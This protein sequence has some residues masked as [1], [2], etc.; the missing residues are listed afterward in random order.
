MGIPRNGFAFFVVVCAAFVGVGLAGTSSQAKAQQPQPNGIRI[1]KVDDA[2]EGEWL[3]VPGYH[4]LGSPTF[5]RDGEWIAFDA[6]KS[7]TEQVTCE[8]WIVRRNG[9]DA[10]KVTVGATPR[11]HPNGRTLIFMRE[12]RNE[13]ESK[14]LGIFTIDRD[15]G[16]ETFLCPGRWPDWSPDGTQI[17]FSHGAENTRNG[18]SAE[19]S[20][21]YVALANGTSPKALA[22][23]DCPSWSSD[24]SKIA[25]CFTDP[26]LPAPLIR[27]I[28]LADNGQRF[29]GYGW[30]RANWDKDG[31]A[32]AFNG[33]TEQQKSGMVS[34]KLG[35]AMKPTALATGI[36][37]ASSPCYSADG[38]YIVFT[39]PH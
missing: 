9:K 5:S 19:L 1:Q 4:Y 12:Q 30:F 34:V 25:C 6:Y 33:V 8:V 21:V 20:R 29:A 27:I 32:V 31:K 35:A 16:A 3:T 7:N 18:G 37:N 10:K 11:W 26:A 22:N 15:G 14:P 38:K 13:V 2:D 28:D 39:A 36:E 17:A 24:G 23:G